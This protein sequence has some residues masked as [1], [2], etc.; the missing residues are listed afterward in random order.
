MNAEQAWQAALG[1]LQMDMSKAAFDTWVKDA[2]LVHYQDG[3]FV[4]GVNNAYARDWLDSRL[5][6][7]VSRMLTG[8]MNRPEVV[9]FVVHQ[10]EVEYVEEAG[11]LNEAEPAGDPVASRPAN[12]SINPRYTFETFVVGASNRLA[13]AACQAVAENPA[14]AYNP[15]FL[16]GGVGLGKTHLLHAIGNAAHSRGLQV[17]YVSSEDFTNEMIN[18]IRTHNT[19]NFRDRYRTIDVLLIDDIQFIAGKESTQEE[20]FHTFNALHGQDK[21]IVM[22]SDRPP[23][24]MVTLEERLR[25]RFEWG[26]TADIQP[27]DLETRIAILRSKAERAGREVPNEILETIARQVQSNIRELEGSLTRVLAFADLSGLPLTPQLV[28]SA[29]ADLLPQRSQVDPQQIVQAVAQA[30]GLQPNQLLGRDR[31]R[32]VALPRQIAM[33]LLREEANV[34]LPQI[35]EALGGRDHTTVI[36]ACEK[37]ADLI[38][39]DDRL[40]RQLIQIREQLYGRSRL[41]V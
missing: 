15:L 1:Q 17:L 37:V 38:E 34:S 23:K 8:M 33:Y 3:R 18:S 41:A 13:H 27:P 14:K 36:Y 30:F 19:S 28:N 20:F 21:Q 11:D 31:T 12:L 35:G 10:R 6:S 2:N 7:T 9:E 26:L 25:S 24:A 29:L 32:E 40:R 22:S 4:I 5:S 39:R 16:Y